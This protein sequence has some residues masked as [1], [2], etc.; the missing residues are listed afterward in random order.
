MIGAL[1]RAGRWL[2]GAGQAVAELGRAVRG[3]R[4]A[5][6]LDDTDPM[7]LTQKSAQYIQQQI[8][9]ATE[10]RH[11]IRPPPPSSRYD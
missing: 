10:Q 8:R 7:P 3:M 4:R 5:V 11:E 2:V 6:L 9:S 1:L